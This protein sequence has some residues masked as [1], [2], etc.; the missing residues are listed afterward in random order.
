MTEEIKEVAGGPV[1]V[2]L[3]MTGGP[4]FHSI[5]AALAPRGRL[6]VYGYASGQTTDV[7]TKV[8]MERSITVSGFWLPSLYSD[9]NALPTSM[10]ALF[11]AVRAGSLRPVLGQVYPLN[12]AGA[13]HAALA[14]R[15]HTG[16]LCLDTAGW[17]RSQSYPLPSVG[18]RVRRPRSITRDEPPQ[19][20]RLVISRELRR[21]LARA[22][23]G[24]R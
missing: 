16:K 7:S 4:T 21:Y 11:D 1:Q 24:D 17:F 5:V 19:T 13:A 8:L 6:A 10:N 9:R 23:L 14:A 3:E 2:A 22:R 20:S 18:T 12:E 15:T